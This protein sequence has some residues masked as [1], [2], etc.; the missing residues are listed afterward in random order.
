[1]AVYTCGICT[2]MIVE[3]VPPG[4]KVPCPACG[5]GM[6]PKAGPGALDMS[7]PDN[8]VRDTAFDMDVP[9]KVRKAAEERARRNPK[10]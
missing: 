10:P 1:M 4:T 3:Q 5:R 9:E 6:L 2:I 7:F 8:A